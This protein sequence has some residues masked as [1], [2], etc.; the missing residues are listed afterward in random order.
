MTVHAHS[1][2]AIEC[3]WISEEEEKMQ[4]KIILR[5]RDDGV[6]VFSS[7]TSKMV[8]FEINDLAT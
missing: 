6:I 7:D 4:L 2:S 1:I 8:A 3:K 5:T